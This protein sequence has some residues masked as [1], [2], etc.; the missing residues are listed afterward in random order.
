MWLWE[1]LAACIL[2]FDGPWIAMGDWNLEPQDLS[3]VGWLDTVNGKVFAPS[4]AACAGE[5]QFSTT[6]CYPRRWHIWCKQVKVVD[7][8]P[9]TPHA[10]VSLPLT[11]TS[12]GHKGIASQTAKAVP[13][14]VP[15]GPQRQEEHFDWTWAAEEPPVD[16][17]LA[18][19]EWLRAAE[20][21]RCHVHDLFGT[22]RRPF[23]F[24]GGAKVWSSS[25]FL[26]ARPR[27]TTRGDAAAKRP[28]LGAPYDAWRR[29]YGR[30][31]CHGRPRSTPRRARSHTS[32]P[33]ASVAAKAPATG[34]Q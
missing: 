24:G 27:A 8:S 12:W 4:A 30:T 34:Q 17:E 32:A 10:P 18:R 26:S 15:V 22:Q 31:L 14:E 25:T 7:N 2:C 19:L 6:S 13:T 21:A 29:S 20:A 9:T 16:L 1:V 3:Q 23:F 5:A 33:A 28:Q 11:A